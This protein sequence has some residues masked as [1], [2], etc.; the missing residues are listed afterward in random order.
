MNSTN[1]Q[2]LVL[3][4]GKST[5]FNTGKS[6]LIEKI[7]GQEMI[8]YATKLLAEFSIKTTVIIGHQ[9]ENIYQIVT[10][11]HRDT[12]SFVTQQSQEGTG[13]AI[14]CAQDTLDHDN[15]LIMNGDAPLVTPEIIQKLIDTHAHENATISFVTAHNADPSVDSY[16]RVIKADNK[17]KIVEARD[18]TGDA[19]EHCCVNAGIYIIKK[20]FLE[21][22]IDKLERN[23][24]SDEFYLTDLIAKASDQGLKV[25][26]INAPFDQI[27]GINTYTELFAA[28]QIKRAELIKYWMSQ[29]VRFS[30][31]QT[32][33]LDLM[34]TIGA[35]T[36]IGCS[37]HLQGSTTIG[38]NCHINESTSL[39]NAIVQ[40]N[41]TI[42]AH[43]IIHDSHIGNSAHVGPFAHVRNGSF[44]DTHVQIGNFV[45]IK[46]STI[47]A[48]TKAKHLAYVGDAQVG[49]KVNIGAGTITCNYDGNNKHIT[50]IEDE[51]FIGSNNTLIAPITIG[52]GSYTAAGSVITHNVPAQALAIG[53]SRQINKEG[54]AN[55]L[56]AKKGTTQT[57]TSEQEPYVAA[58]KIRD[59]F[60][61]EEL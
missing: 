3:A 39:H 55:K 52:Q 47:G 23:D 12:I 36:Y 33:H 45:E 48:H 30:A 59:A 11:H 29:G 18:F 21:N 27:R 35:G 25:A 15:V 6:K 43:T 22:N 16:G 54:Y 37:V 8:L 53:R 9:K 13:H 60:S 32:V 34:V 10:Q 26:T 4:A 51:A 1:I 50:T 42:D 5:R 2:A 24:K 14:L 38:T 19:H 7:C 46:N 28:E 40:D 61:T 41:A 57:E 44:I 49:T 20:E 56:K 58:M 31:P 17:I